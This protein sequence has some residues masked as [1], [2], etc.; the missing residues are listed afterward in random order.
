LQKVWEHVLNQ[1]P[2]TELTQKQVYAAWT[3]HNQDVW[4]FNNEQIQSALLN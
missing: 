2:D 3:P 1:Y 4:G